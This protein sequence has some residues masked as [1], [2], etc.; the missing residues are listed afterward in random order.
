MVNAN[1]LIRDLKIAS[2]CNARWDDME[3]SD[4]SR[5][6]RSCQKNV[7]N[8]TS[9]SAEEARSLLTQREGRVCGRFY[10]RS[11]GTVLTQ[12][13][14]IGLHKRLRKVI[15]ATVLLLFAATGA[16]ALGR[17]QGRQNDFQASRAR[18]YVACSSLMWEVKGWFGI[19]RPMLLGEIAVPLPRT[20]TPPS[21]T[22]T[23]ATP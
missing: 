11:D 18:L 8:F 14:P 7:Y 17:S 2:P 15:Y 6:C 13:C 3:G 5:F 9:L 1:S 12:D 21:G 22:G 4:F 10:R 20:P 23:L 16:V 19:R